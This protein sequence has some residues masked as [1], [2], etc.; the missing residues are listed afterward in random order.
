VTST[1][2]FIPET[3]GQAGQPRA[4]ARRARLSKRGAADVDPGVAGRESVGFHTV[5]DGQCA[6][7]YGQEHQNVVAPGP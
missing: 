3:V 4:P 1:Q 5:A 6:G 7:D 2:R